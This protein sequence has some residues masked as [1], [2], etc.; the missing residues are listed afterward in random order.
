MRRSNARKDMIY[1]WVYLTIF[2]LVGMLWLFFK[3]CY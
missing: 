3:G 2:V 1:F